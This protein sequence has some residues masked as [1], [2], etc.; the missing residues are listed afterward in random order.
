MTSEEIKRLSVLSLIKDR[1]KTNKKMY[2]FNVDILYLPDIEN[3]LKDTCY[4]IEYVDKLFF[5]CDLFLKRV[6]K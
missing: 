6:E 4:R 1:L 5:T 2:H 3:L